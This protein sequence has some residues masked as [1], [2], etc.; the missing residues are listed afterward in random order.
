MA[1]FRELLQQ[2]KSQIR[3]VGTAEAEGLLADG[4]TLLEVREPD[5][6][7]QEPVHGRA[8]RPARRD[9]AGRREPGHR[10]RCCAVRG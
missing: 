2:A 5:E 6:Y 7:E 8:P 9:G 3:E 4:W 10:R 1:T